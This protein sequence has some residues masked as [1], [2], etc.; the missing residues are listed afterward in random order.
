MYALARII[1]A[2]PFAIGLMVFFWVK[3]AGWYSRYQQA[4]GKP[5]ETELAT[6]Y[7]MPAQSIPPQEDAE[8]ENIRKRFQANKNGFYAVMAVFFLWFIGNFVFG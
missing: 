6:T 8:L 7:F 1:I 5:A 3:A 2:F 4:T